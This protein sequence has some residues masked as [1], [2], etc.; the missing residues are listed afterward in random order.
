MTTLQKIIK[1]CA[2]AFAI[3][4]TVSI[5]SGIF[6][7]L[8]M[9]VGFTRT[10][11]TGPIQTYPVSGSVQ[12]LDLEIGAA[13]L[14]IVTGDRFQVESN[15]KYLTVKEKDGT[16]KVTEEKTAI[17]TS[18]DG[19]SVVVTIPEGFV[20]ERAAITTGA[21]KVYIASLCADTVKMELGAGKTDID[22]LQARS[23]S[24]ISTGA[25]KLTIRDCELHNLDMELGVGK[26]TLTGRLT[27]KCDIE[28]G[29]GNAE[30]TL[31][32]SRDDYQIH[33]EKGLGS[34]TLDGRAMSNDSVYGGG[35]NRI[36]IEGGIGSMDIRFQDR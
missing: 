30:L 31:L 28:Y 21:G 19:V 12:D 25:G 36:E 15:H 34:A 17:G 27:G 32:G 16:L 20:F 2:M 24:K 14:K 10:D 4:L 9:L 13:S 8:G 11:V 33:L 6:G 35:E 23:R 29:I 5:F 7:A 3:F 22:D 18:E 26:Q 1:Y